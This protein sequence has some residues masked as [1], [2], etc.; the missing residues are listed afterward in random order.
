MRG[1]ILAGIC[2]GCCWLEFLS[3]WRRLVKAA[4][5][6]PRRG[7]SAPGEL[8]SY[9]LRL[10][11]G[12]VLEP[13]GDHPA[14]RILYEPNGERSAQFMRPVPS[15]FASPDPLKATAE[16]SDRAW[17]NYIG[18]WGKY[19][20]DSEARAVVHHIESGW[21][22]NWIGQNKIRSF[23]FDRDRLVLDAESPAGHATL[24]WRKLN[25]ATCA[26]CGNFHPKC[27]KFLD[28]SNHSARNGHSFH[29]VSFKVFPIVQP[30]R[31]Y[32]SG[33]KR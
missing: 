21:F 25:R 5:R 12:T 23:R 26:Y 19:G 9:Q 27:V 31:Q 10:P 29:L 30:N 16:E 8:I 4:I 7:S 22:P 15:H 33:G 1:K 17:R 14:G 13:F 6:P 11:S 32:S 3:H 18:Y 20:V 2:A 28:S 24:V